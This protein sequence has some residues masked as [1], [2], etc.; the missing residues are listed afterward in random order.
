MSHIRTCKNRD[1]DL[2]EST[3]NHDW[4]HDRITRS[5][6][7]KDLT[8]DQHLGR[9][10]T[11]FVPNLLFRLSKRER[12]GLC[13]KVGK[14]NAVMIDRREFIQ[15]GGRCNK[16]SRNDLRPLMNKLVKGVLTVCTGGTPYNRLKATRSERECGN[17]RNNRGTDSY[18]CLV[19][20]TVTILCHE[21]TIRLHVSLRKKIIILGI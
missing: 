17:A 4:E 5:V 16:I 12:L 2:T 14:E 1:L 3:R 6:S 20:N 9:P 7:F 13:K 18:P 21:F 19:I 15:G 8:L 11:K 10:T